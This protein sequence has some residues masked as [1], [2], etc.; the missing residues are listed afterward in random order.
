MRRFPYTYIRCISNQVIMNLT[1]HIIIRF[2]FVLFALILAPLC[3][4]TVNILL[5]SYSGVFVTI[6]ALYGYKCLSI[7]N[8]AFS[9][10][11]LVNVH[12]FVVL[13]NNSYILQPICI[14]QKSP[15]NVSFQ[16]IVSH[17]ANFKEF[18]KY[19]KYLK[20]ES[21]AHTLSVVLNK[22]IQ[23]R[24]ASSYSRFQCYDN[25]I[26]LKLSHF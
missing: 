3:C 22:L 8:P 4:F 18:M 9:A 20:Y 17:P 13:G 1:I 11:A 12:L 24:L 19:I 23:F 21:I 26:T 16:R 2:H 5:I 14:L 15:K 7:R 6:G 10:S 25:I